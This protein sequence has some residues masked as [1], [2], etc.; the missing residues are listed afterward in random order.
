MLG[1]VYEW[2]GDWF[3]P[4]ET[5]SQAN[6]T[7]P[8]EGDS[9]VLRGGSWVVSPRNVRVSGRGGLGPTYRVFSIGFRCVG[10]QRLEFTVLSL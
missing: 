9:K 1:N 2:C 5:G 6:P 7:G 4:Y 3:G 10:E 8:K